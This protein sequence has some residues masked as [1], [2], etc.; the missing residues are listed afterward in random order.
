MAGCENVSQATLTT[1]EREAHESVELLLRKRHMDLTIDGI[2]E[3][4]HVPI[5]EFLR[6][7]ARY[8]WPEVTR[9]PAA[10]RRPTWVCAISDEVAESDGRTSRIAPIEFGEPWAALEALD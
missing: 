4:T 6:A 5:E 7:C 10:G 2:N 3:T 1:I 8:G 9:H